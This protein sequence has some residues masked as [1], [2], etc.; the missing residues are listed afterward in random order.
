MPT[1]TTTDH[2]EFL[3]ELLEL[4]SLGPTDAVLAARQVRRNHR[5]I[6]AARRT[7]SGLRVLEAEG[8]VESGADGREFRI[9]A[10]GIATLE[11]RG[12]FPGGAVVM[13]T[14][15]VASTE[16]IARFGE[17]GAHERRQRH[18]ELLR[19]E[20]AAAGGREVKN[21]GDGLMVVFADPALATECAAQMQRAVAADRDRL[22]LR[23]GLHA[24]DLLREGDDYFGTTVIVARRLCEVAGAGQIL[25]SG[26]LVALAGETNARTATQLRAIELKGL[27][28]P[29]EGCELAWQPSAVEAEG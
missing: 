8:L 20:L 29:V 22:G 27:G 7:A 25:A 1:T 2:A 17:D 5:V 18:F 10:S 4:T 6:R 11:E 26:V 21:L 9:T 15:L 16:L 13:F 19:R 12:R 14:D 24:G 23:I 28:L 3:L